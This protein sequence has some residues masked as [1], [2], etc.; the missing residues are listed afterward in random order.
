[1]KQFLSRLYAKL[2]IE[3]EYHRGWRHCDERLINGDPLFAIEAE[4]EACQANDDYDHGFYDR[5]R[6]EVGFRD[7]L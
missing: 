5:L 4:W 6:E 3:R 1:M 7:L 2:G